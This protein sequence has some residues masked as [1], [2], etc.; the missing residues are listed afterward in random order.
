M[1]EGSFVGDVRALVRHENLCQPLLSC[2]CTF[3]LIIYCTPARLSLKKGIL[4][5]HNGIQLSEKHQRQNRNRKCLFPSAA[6]VGA[7]RHQ[8]VVR[9]PHVDIVR[10]AGL[11]SNSG[12]WPASGHVSV[13]GTRSLDAESSGYVAK[14]LVCPSTLWTRLH[15]M[16]VAAL[17]KQDN[18]HLPARTMT[19]SRL[20]RAGRFTWAAF[21]RSSRTT[22]CHGY[23]LGE[24]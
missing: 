4:A 6:A 12:W 11:G 9:R 5:N 24:Y 18:A 15:Y 2:Y 16:D 23:R 21:T 3:V 17:V 20:F 8:A 22:K 1:N 19:P 7:S 10:F 14:I 13:V